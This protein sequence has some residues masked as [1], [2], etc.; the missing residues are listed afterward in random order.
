MNFEIDLDGAVRTVTVETGGPG[1]YRVVVDGEVH[2]VQ[3]ERAGE[4][5]LLVGMGGASNI[6]R[7]VQ[8]APGAARGECLVTRGGRTVAVIVNGRTRRRGT[9]EDASRAGRQPV[10]R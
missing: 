8:I 6:S 1:W 2:D 9:P 10:V 5:G 7:E 3:A 4:C